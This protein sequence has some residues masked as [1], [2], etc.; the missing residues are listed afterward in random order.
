MCNSARDILISMLSDTIHA[1]AILIRH[2]GLAHEFK[3]IWELKK[4]F[5]F[6][7]VKAL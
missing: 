2:L 5:Q 6:Q 1:C 3:E 4:E 7:A